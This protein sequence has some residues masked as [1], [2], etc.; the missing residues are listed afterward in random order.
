[1]I[2]YADTLKPA[3]TTMGE[4]SLVDSASAL[5]EAASGCR[6]HR[7]PASQKCKF[8]SVGKWRKS[9]KQEDPVP[10]PL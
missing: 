3:I 1:M 5:F 4:F 10:G 2:S 7:N 6:L 8:L 9:L